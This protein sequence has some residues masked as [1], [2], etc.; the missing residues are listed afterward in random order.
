MTPEQFEE[1]CWQHDLTY[2]YSDDY[3]MYNRGEMT[4]RTIK[5]AAYEL[6]FDVAAPI[7]NK[8]V[9]RKLSE[10]N[11]MP[12]LWGEPKDENSNAT[13][14]EASTDNWLNNGG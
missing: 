3:R 12:F 7:W 4:Y 10:Y 11:R 1:L 6:G 5:D 9:T 13:D 14:P 8:V 2:V